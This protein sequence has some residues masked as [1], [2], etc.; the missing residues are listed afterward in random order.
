MNGGTVAFSADQRVKA[1]IH[2]GGLKHTNVDYSFFFYIKYFTLLSAFLPTRGT[3][4][5]ASGQIKHFLHLNSTAP[6][7][8]YYSAAFG[9][10][11]RVIKKSYNS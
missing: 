9:A 1:I 2:K 4:S 7:S 3:N 11:Q 5:T 10:D 6:F 8:A